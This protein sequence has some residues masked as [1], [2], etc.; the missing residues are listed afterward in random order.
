MKSHKNIYSSFLYLYNIL[1]FLSTLDGHLGSLK[2]WAVLKTVLT[3]APL[4]PLVNSRPVFFAHI[5]G[6][7]TSV[8]PRGDAAQRLPKVA[9]LS[10][11]TVL[12]QEEFGG[13]KGEESY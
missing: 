9:L 13:I 5:R 2:V 4:H 6:R 3:Q 10:S 12:I 8:G 1:S 11:I 7:K